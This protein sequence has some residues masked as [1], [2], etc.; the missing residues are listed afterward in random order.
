MHEQIITDAAWCSLCRAEC[1]VEVVW[2]VDDP[3]PVAVCLDCGSGVDC[4]F[5]PTLLRPAGTR[6]RRAS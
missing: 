1:A 3:G 4:W 6:R 5:D 2:L